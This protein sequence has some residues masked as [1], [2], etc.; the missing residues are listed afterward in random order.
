MATL[1]LTGMAL[2]AAHGAS[3]APAAG[4]R[5]RVLHVCDCP[6]AL[7]SDERAALLLAFAKRGFVLGRNLTLETYDYETAGAG[8][9]PGA[10]FGVGKAAIANEYSPFLERQ[11]PRMQAQIV[12]ASGVRVVQAA[13]EVGKETPVVFWRVTDP[14][15]FG[16]VKTLAQ[17]G[18]TLT[19]FSRALEKL[20]VK[21]LE[22]LNEMLPRAR[23]IGFLFIEDNVHH[24][25]Q[26]DDVRRAADSRRLSLVNYPLP[27]NEW[28]AERLEETFVQMRRDG[29]DAFLL[30]DV[31][32]QGQVVVALA[33]KYRLPT[34]YAL[35]HV[36][37]DWGGLAAY[38][39]SAPD[40]LFG[41][42]DYAVRVLKGEMARDL[43][44]QEPAQFELVLNTRAANAIGVSFPR[45]FLLRAT[46]VVDR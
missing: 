4:P 8:S 37:T 30:P 24:R 35:S 39:T 5:H 1:C 42:A 45:K 29:M 19:G 6:P 10:L 28:S 34:I 9:T 46:R 18:G 41:V 3:S 38:T 12:L 23:R 33:A 31:N 13:Q 36:V 44:V 40:E 25:Q 20:T 22:L 11:I 17:P 43:P 14:V 32:V 15:G 16:F 26:A 21:R 2:D 27:L 7:A